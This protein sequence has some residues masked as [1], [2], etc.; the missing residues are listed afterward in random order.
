TRTPSRA[1]P[2][3]RTPP[4]ARASG[5]SPSRARAALPRAAP[6]PSRSARRTLRATSR[7][8]WRPSRP[9]PR[10]WAA[11][12]LIFMATPPAVPDGFV[13][14]AL[15]RYGLKK[16]PE[17]VIAQAKDP[18]KSLKK[19]LGALDLTLLGIAA[20]IGAGIFVYAGLGAQIA[21]P[22][23]VWSF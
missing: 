4:P 23:V 7:S 22:H 13:A 1:S 9:R 19:T 16:A 10:P 8:P 21:G 17:D 15:H 14:R 6:S 2:R 20:I 3:T 18:T 11:S 5:P 12:R